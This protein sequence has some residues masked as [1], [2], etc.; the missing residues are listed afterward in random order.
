MWNINWFWI[1]LLF[2]A[3]LVL[4]SC[5]DG[6]SPP[7]TPKKALQSFALADKDLEVMLVASEPLVQDPVAMTFDAQ[8][9]LWVVEMLSF[10]MDIEGSGEQ[11]RMGRVTVLFDDD[12]DGV[13]DRNQ[14][15]LDSLHLPR[16][17][18]V[19]PEGVLV[20][21]Q[22]PLWFV[23][24]TNADFLA[25]E[26]ILVDSNYGG[27][28]LPEHSANGLWW[29]MD[30]WYYNAKSRSR[31]RQKNGH[32]EEA[33]TEFRGQWGICHDDEGRLFYN[34]NWSQLHADLVPPNYLSRN[35]HHQSSTGIDHGLTLNRKIYPIRSNLAVN[36]G[37]VPGTLDEEGKLLEFASACA[38][39]IYRGNLIPSLR[40]DAFVCEPTG[41]LIKRNQIREDGFILTAQDAYKNQEF[42]ASTDERFRPIF[43]SDGPDGALYLVDMYRGIIQHGPYMSD[44]LR[45]VTLQRK[46]DQHIHLGRIWKIVPKK[47]TPVAKKINGASLTELVSL[48]ADKNGWVRDRAMQQLIFLGTPEVVSAMEKILQGDDNLSKIHALWI[49]H[50]VNHVNPDQLLPLVADSDAAVAQTAIRVM[51]AHPQPDDQKVMIQKTFHDYYPD[52]H[53]KAQLQIML[54]ADQF[55]W[56]IAEALSLDF[57][58]RFAHL[59][60][61]RDVVMSTLS[62][63]EVRMWQTINREWLDKDQHREI[64][65]ENLAA[66]I[67][68]RGDPE[69][70]S[71][72]LNE[73]GQEHCDWWQS[74]IQGMASHRRNIDSQIR[75]KQ[76]PAALALIEI[77]YPQIRPQLARLEEIL[78]WPEKPNKQAIGED[79]PINL[80]QEVFAQ[81]RQ[82]YLNLCASCHG[83]QGEGMAR[84]APPLAN[85]QWVLGD[86]DKLSMILLHGMEGPIDVNGK[87][88]DIPEILPVMPSFSTLQNQDI[89]AIATYI[90]NTWEHSESVIKAQ[91]VGHIRYRTQGKITPWTAAELDTFIFNVDL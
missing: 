58:D 22:M 7:L 16:A 2:A 5:M 69:E 80:D 75:L 44:Y 46:L 60:M 51:M 37:Y 13:M 78:Q 76:K 48:L 57:L 77:K 33:P 65:V 88:Y 4:V 79:K 61:A 85:S 71:F 23:K 3:S 42:L 19:T 62:G 8:G 21:E 56:P 50:A 11:N 24:D 54:N 39:F 70:I 82:K 27:L 15:F 63:R 25:D 81:G 55:A 10:M 29:A 38:P 43:L 72:L 14:I 36:R 30:G 52:L 83:T 67:V 74:S 9:N 66:A 73:L 18:A 20:A 12:N 59:P 90:R 34:Y 32:W 35:P 28:P 45:K 41:N 86:P 87:Y 17:I 6:T 68:N 31:Y 53:P 47:N 49:L 91:R 1:Y 84:F 89:A 26:K 40:G 64:F